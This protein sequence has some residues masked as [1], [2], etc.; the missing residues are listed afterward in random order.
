VG[1]V[2]ILSGGGLGY[3]TVRELAT[4]IPDPMG[5]P[6]RQTDAGDFVT[7]TSYDELGRP[8]LESDLLTKAPPY[9]DL[10][11]HVSFALSDSC[12][13]ERGGGAA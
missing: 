5:N 6:T 7:D 1:T 13:S 2:Q 11:S 3:G 9:V 10:R 4:A 12:I 8:V